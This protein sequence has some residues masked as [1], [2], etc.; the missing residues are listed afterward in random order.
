MRQ[1]T[2]STVLLLTAWF[3][4]A[5][6]PVFVTLGVIYRKP[7]WAVSGLLLAVYGLLELRRVRHARAKPTPPVDPA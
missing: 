6:A 3:S 4:L 1:A 5:V 7:E 2:I